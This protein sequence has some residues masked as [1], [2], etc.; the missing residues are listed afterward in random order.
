[1]TIHGVK[2]EN[3]PHSVDPDAD[4]SRPPLKA[5]VRSVSHVNS[6]S[7]KAASEMIGKAAN[8]IILAG[9]GVI[10][11]DA[12]EAL[13]RFA[14]PS[15]LPVAVTFH[16]KGAISD[17]HPNVIGAVG[18][19]RGDYENLSFDA[20]DLIFAV[21]YEIQEFDPARINPNG[22]NTMVHL[23]EFVSGCRYM[24]PAVAQPDRRH[25]LHP[26]CPRITAVAAP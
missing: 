16:G 3:H 20:A 2:H 9:H 17:D 6:V 15:G 19:M 25:S 10:R 11:G 4:D 23:H 24:L 13:R 5:A 12:S 22:H 8:P 18:F 14:E 21:G 26:G 7:L 1:M